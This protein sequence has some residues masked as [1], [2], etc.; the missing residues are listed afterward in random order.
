MPEQDYQQQYLK[1]IVGG[2][3]PELRQQKKGM[4]DYLLQN[5]LRTGQSATSVAEGLRP[6]AQ[7]SGQAAA[8][9]GVQASS[10]ARQQEQ[11]DVQQQN[12]QSSF[13]QGQ[14]NWE[15]EMSARDE[16]QDLANMMAMFESTGWTQEL[17]DAMGFSAESAGSS[18][19]NKLLEDL[20]FS[21][22]QATQEQGGKKSYWDQGH[23]T[24]WQAGKAG[25]RGQAWRNQL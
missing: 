10:M 12:W 19:F 20:G 6:Y 25:Q 11:F 2:F 23:D 13:D 14:E 16:Q 15:K 9:A 8:E 1:E 5:S 17:L 18:S 22:P 3:M 21:N 4:Y 7:A 24:T